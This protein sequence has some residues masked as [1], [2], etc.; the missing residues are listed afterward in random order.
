MLKAKGLI[1]ER[2]GAV[3]GKTVTFNEILS[4]A[5]MEKQKMSVC[6]PFVVTGTV[7]SYDDVSS[8][9]VTVKLG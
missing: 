2:A 3:L 7:T 5:Y 9:T 6:V 8:I 4:A 1:E